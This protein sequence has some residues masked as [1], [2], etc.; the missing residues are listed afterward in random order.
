VLAD[1]EITH[2]WGGP[3]GVARDWQAS[4]GFDRST[5]LAWAGGY[6]GD[7]VATTNLA[8]RTLARLIRGDDDSLIHLPWVDHRSPQWPREPMRWLGANAALRAMALADAVEERN[9]RPSR[10]AGAVDSILGR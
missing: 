3:L 10:I 1:V 5:G 2:R 8:G 4:V 9:G 6:V 7:G